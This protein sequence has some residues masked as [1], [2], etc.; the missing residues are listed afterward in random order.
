MALLVW[1][2]VNPE[3]SYLLGKRWMFKEEPDISEAD[4]FMFRLSSI[5]SLIIVV[6]LFVAWIIR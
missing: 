6:L 3:E 2:I 1:S 4:I 5:V